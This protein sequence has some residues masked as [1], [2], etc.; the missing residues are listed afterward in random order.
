MYFFRNR[1]SIFLPDLFL[2]LKIVAL[3]WIESLL[4]NS[5]FDACA[6]G[7]IYPLGIDRNCSSNIFFDY[8]LI[9][10]KK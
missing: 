5:G 7:N 10:K 1:L 9:N 6:H 3:D 8:P 2:S 4:R